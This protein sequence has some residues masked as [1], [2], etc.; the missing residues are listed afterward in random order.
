MSKSKRRL[1]SLILVVVGL[2]L[3]FWGYQMSSS[4]GSQFSK[5]F[6]GS[7]SDKVMMFY[8]IGAVSFFVGAYAFLTRK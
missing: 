8:V 1:I 6:T 2:G 7:Y 5:A 4:V 3:I